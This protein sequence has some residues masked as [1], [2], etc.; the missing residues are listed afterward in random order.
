MVGHPVSGFIDNVHGRGLGAHLS[1]RLFKTHLRA[2]LEALPFSPHGGSPMKVDLSFL[3]GFEEPIVLIPTQTYDKRGLH[4]VLLVL[5]LRSILVPVVGVLR[6]LL[7]IGAATLAGAL[8]AGIAGFLKATVGAHEVIATI[9]LPLT[10]VTGI[11]GM[12]VAVPGEGASGPFWAIIAVLVVLGVAIFSTTVLV[13]NTLRRR[14]PS[15]RFV[16]GVQFAIAG[17]AIGVTLSLGLSILRITFADVEAN[18]RLGDY[19][20]FTLRFLFAFGVAF[21]FPVFLFAAA[22]AGVISSQQLARGRR[23]AVLIIVIGAAVITP[24]GEAFSLMVLP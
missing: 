10:L 4:V 5:V 12:N 19:Y 2:N 24:S 9:M 7:A 6:F 3:R 17:A 8:W 22:A 14:L 21:L 18:R 20:S 15:N 13:L 1:H 23:W 11:F 16:R